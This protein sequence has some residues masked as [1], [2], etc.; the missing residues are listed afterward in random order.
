MMHLRVGK[1]PRGVSSEET[2]ASLAFSLGF[3][4]QLRE[5]AI[6]SWSEPSGGGRQTKQPVINSIRHFS[7]LREPHQDIFLGREALGKFQKT[8]TANALP[9]STFPYF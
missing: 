9:S 8:K 3:S 2:G 1:S 6:K 4:A 5:M 7:G